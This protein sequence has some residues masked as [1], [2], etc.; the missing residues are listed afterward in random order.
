MTE[1]R[2]PQ[3][4]APV[5]AGVEFCVACGRSIHSLIAGT[6]LLGRYEIKDLL[7]GGGM[8]WV[9]RAHDRSLDE[10]VAVKVLRRDISD[11][12]TAALRFRSEIKAARR[13]RNPFVCA[14]HDYGEEGLVRFITMELVLGVTLKD[15]VLARGA[16]PLARGLRLGAE[17]AEGLGAMH[18]AGI[19]HRDVKCGN[20]MIDESD[21]ARL[22]DFG[23]SRILGDAAHPTRTGQNM[24][25]P[26]YM[27]PEQAN[28][29]KVDARSDLYSMGVVLYEVFVG[30]TPFQ[31]DT[32][33]A[34]LLK[35]LQE[36]PLLPASSGL[37]PRLADLIR[38][39]LEKDPAHRPADVKELRARLAAIEGDR[40]SAQFAV[41]QSGEVAVDERLRQSV[42]APP[43]TSRT[44]PDLAEKVGRVVTPEPSLAEALAILSKQEPVSWPVVSPVAH[45]VAPQ[46]VAPMS[47]VSPR[48]RPGPEPPTKTKSDPPRPAAGGARSSSSSHSGLHQRQ[49]LSVPLQPLRSPPP[50]RNTSSLPWIAA[51]LVALIASAASLGVLWIGLRKAFPSS[52][53]AGDDKAERSTNASPAG[54]SA[55]RKADDS[56]GSNRKAPTKRP[57]TTP[58]PPSL[59]PRAPLTAVLTSLPEPALSSQISTST[60]A[61]TPSPTPTP[62]PVVPA[63]PGQLHLEAMPFA[64][65]SINGKEMGRTPI[66]VP[67]APGTYTVVFSV[68]GFPPAQRTVT[69]QSG[70]TVS[71]SVSFLG[72][73]QANGAPQE[74]NPTPTPSLPSVREDP[75]AMWR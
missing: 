62:Q 14:I 53:R 25:T 48:P 41:T 9:Y 17:L 73:P 28:G 16:L 15:E 38:A 11:A 47:A 66:R 31:A 3:C 29:T 6:V 13:V 69:V 1:V 72:S 71:E 67:M 42:P 65:V 40:V 70:Q 52:S 33:A 58:K 55:Q 56:T 21:H 63:A 44:T 26:E 60:P 46:A 37:P 8:G 12:A 61:P 50:R 74:S 57:A 19:L 22:M 36:P 43:E 27:S 75:H 59:Q 18:E 45:P 68:R 20:V 54:D 5:R 23:V 34:V 2:C 35:H 10:P 64:E 30:R 39:L 4:Q 24:G 51:I 49:V 7:G 32:P